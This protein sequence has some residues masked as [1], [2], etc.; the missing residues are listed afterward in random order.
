MK[1]LHVSFVLLLLSCSSLFAQSVNFKVKL[2]ELKANADNNDGGGVAGSQDPVWYFWV[3]DNGTTGNSYGA[4]WQATGC[5]SA[6]NQFGQWWAGG[7]V[8][9]NFPNVSNS[10]ATIIHTRI[11]GFEDDGCDATCTFTSSG[12]FLSAC[13]ANG[14][15]NH[16]GPSPA[17]DINFR[18]DPPCQWN[19]YEV[20][21]G[22]YF[23]R[24]QVYWE[25]STPIT[26]GQV[27]G[28]QTICGGGDPTAFTSVSGFSPAHSSFTYQWQQDPGCTGNFTD[29]VGAVNATYDPPM[30]V[31]QST[32]YRRVTLTACGSY[33]SNTVTVSV[34]TAS[35]DPSGA[36]ASNNTVCNG[37]ATTLS[38]SGGSLGSG[39]QYV[40][41]QG[42]CG[43]GTSVGTGSSISV[44]PTSSTQ[45][46]ARI[47]SG[48]YQGSCVS[49]SIT[50]NQ[51]STAATAIIPSSTQ[52]CPG[53]NVTLSVQGGALANGDT[54][55]WYAGSCG[56]I[57]IGSGSII[58]INPTQTTTYYVRAEGS[59][60]STACASL[61]L[62]VGASSTVPSS[63]SV[64]ANNICPGTSTTLQQ[65]GGAL[66]NND[67]WVWYTGACGAVPVGVGNS[68]DVSPNETTTYFVRAV[69]DCGATLCQTVTVNVQN[70]SV[71]PESVIASDNNFCKGS[72][73]TL[74]VQGGSLVNGA[75]WTWYQSTCGG[76]AIGTG[77]SITVTP[78]SSNTYFVRA[79]GGSCGNT[80]CASVFIN[81]LESYVY[82]VPFDTLCGLKEPFQLTGGLP[83]GGTYSGNG[84]T[85]GTFQ[86]TQVGY[87]SSTIYYSVTDGNGCTMTDSTLLTIIPSTVSG[88][89]EVKILECAD[90]GVTLMVYPTGSLTGDYTFTWNTGEFGNPLKNVPQGNYA[91]TIGD[92]TGCTY[93]VDNLIVS[94]T[95]LCLNIANTISPNGD[96]YNDTWNVDVTNIGQITS[97]KVFSK[98]GQVVWEESNV[99]SF[100]WDGTFKGDP[101]P[102][103]TYY[104]VMEIDNPDY[105][106]QTGPITIVR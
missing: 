88:T 58:S 8:P 56:G 70:G 84:I 21:F 87:G 39:A 37:Q 50:V 103:G 32:C 64:S 2:T 98:W 93:V 33:N 51:S 102:A 106:K 63:V 19:Q 97:V 36:N 95:V 44:S 48:C 16:D 60:G 42:G 1:K 62:T 25:F 77:T 5:I 35:T 46:F 61:L 65:V 83:V 99:T 86:S 73:T 71:A 24:V 13:W 38:V 74:S 72:S 91:V 69:G 3:N 57:P 26:G 75:N 12:S 43:S 67:V 80:D 41:Y 94:E 92:G 27:A 15:D 54:W 66:Q 76:T 11:E 53:Q 89:A 30:G 14:D 81:V 90:G 31:V 104:Y 34:A 20:S 45:Y 49:V 79:E 23:A 40:W 7:P 18:N 101:L 29:I 68:I 47:E 10:D 55:Q 82:M 59:C 78:G 17:G 85:N 96:A 4:T 52:V 6:T 28:D 105:G 9:F 100:N 22:D